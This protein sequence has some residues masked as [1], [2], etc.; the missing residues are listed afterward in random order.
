MPDNF[1]LFVDDEKS[2]LNSIERLFSEDN[3][4]ILKANSAEEAM[5][6]MKNENI[7]VLVSDNFMPGM[8]GVELL[9]K[10]K[11]I[12]PDIVRILMTGQADLSTAIDAINN[13]EVFRFIMKPWD[14]DVFR[15]T[16]KAGIERHQ[17]IRSL[18][19]ADESTMLSLAR[20]IELKD[21]YTRGHC[22]RVA[23]YA[24][25]IAKALN[26]SE[27]AKREIRYGSWLHDCGKIGIPESILNK[28]GSLDDDEFEII[29]K[30]P[31]WG[32][33]VAKQAH[34]SETIINIILYHHE[35]Y[36]GKGYPS[37][38]HGEKIPVEAR[39]VSVADCFDALTTN[40]PYRNAYSKE[41][42]IEIILSMK[43]KNFDSGIVDLFISNLKN[44]R[45]L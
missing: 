17:V 26:F 43:G 11:V 28:Q 2:I 40:R 6:L 31:V 27:E 5:G 13:G 36:D 23:Y 16:V 20:T 45:V 38:I 9:S 44:E 3:M 24:L 37:G 4:S 42:G 39:I 32:E 25:I 21:R 18:K 14:D 8:K 19:R 7:A 10:A 12:A 33:D 22:D 34:L 30:H 1:V 15:Q 41:K 35:R 29:K